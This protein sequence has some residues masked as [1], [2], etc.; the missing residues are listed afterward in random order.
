MDGVRARGRSRGV[1]KEQGGEAV[2]KE[3][4]RASFCFAA[5]DCSERRCGGCSIVPQEKENT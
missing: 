3:M 5:A 2:R 1:W 4:V